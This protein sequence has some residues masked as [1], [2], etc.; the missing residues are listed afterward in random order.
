MA[1]TSKV[2]APSRTQE[3]AIEIE[4]LTPSIGAV[5]RNVDLA[6]QLTEKQYATIEKVFHDHLVIF[7]RDQKLTREDQ[8]RFGQH[9]GKLNVHPFLPKV[10]DDP[11]VIL[12]EN[13]RD[14]PAAVNIWHAD[15]TFMEKPPLGSVL[16][17][18]HVPDV[19]GDTLWADMYAAY[20]SLSDKMQRTV[21]DL[22]AVHKGFLAEYR[23]A[24]GDLAPL[25]PQ[26]EWADPEPTAEH[27]IVRTH[28]VTGKKSLFISSA[29][30][31][32]IK[33]MKTNEAEPLLKMLCRHAQTPEFQVRFRWREGDIA[34][35]DNRCTQHYANADYWPNKRTMHR[36]T[37]E[38]DRPY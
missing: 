2:T 28:P 15:L 36:V 32:E 11:H 21:S 14:R 30:T 1:T 17:A 6:Q 10:E 25:D 35:W 24:L 9:F 8:K 20:E 7:F 22:V 29:D 34:F 18:R 5:I 16:L 37:I 23:A 4:P 31:R 26:S 27:P 12:L 19:G 3:A 38:G 13:D 33:D